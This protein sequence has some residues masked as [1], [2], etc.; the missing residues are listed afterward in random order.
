MMGGLGLKNAQ[1]FGV[2][3]KLVLVSASKKLNVMKRIVR[4]RN[5]QP[6]KSCNIMLI[7][8]FSFHTILVFPMSFFIG[9]SFGS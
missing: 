7:R 6:R 8:D 3:F 1:C 2:T 4:K 9:K 5:L